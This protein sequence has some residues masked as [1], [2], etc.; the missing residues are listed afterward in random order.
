MA[1]LPTGAE[2]LRAVMRWVGLLL[3][4]LITRLAAAQQVE[5]DPGVILELTP[6][7]WT[8]GVSGKV[9]VQGETFPI[10]YS[11]GDIA[12]FVNTGLSA[13][14]ELRDRNFTLV[15]SGLY[16]GV[17]QDSATLRL[18]TDQY[19]VDGFFGYRVVGRLDLMVGGRYFN[20]KATLTDDGSS[21]GDRTQDWVDFSAGARYEWRISR[22]WFLRFRGDV[23]GSTSGASSD[24]SLGA[25]G[26][27]RPLDR[28]AIALSYRILSVDYETDSGEDKFEYDLTY[29]G[30]GLGVMFS[31]F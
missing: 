21:I 16:V 9:S 27:Y 19:V 12:K 1:P 22:K 5:K 26:H 15:F 2:L 28:L 24:W 14:L 20:V 17:T 10:D 13:Q 30:P 31:L 11:G 29:T 8:F 7:V 18:D 4:P 25:S 6:Y 3:I 23:G